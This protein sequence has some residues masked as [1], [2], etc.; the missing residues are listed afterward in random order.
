[1]L[2]VLRAKS[3]KNQKGFT[4]I[5]LLAVIV[6]LAILAAIAIP[7]VISIIN[8]QS[9]K[10][11]VQDALTI[12]NGAKLFVADHNINGNGPIYIQSGQAGTTSSG[13][14]TSTNDG[15]SN[16][17]KRS[18]S[19]LPNA[20]VVYNNGTYSITGDTEISSISGLSGDSATGGYTENTLINF[21]K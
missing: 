10:A 12:I 5:E 19:D 14:D 21:N 9:N 15:W 3:K 7:S 16:Y 17:A 4:L 6:I 2:K 18:T 13:T 8:S 20:V 11:K 1:M